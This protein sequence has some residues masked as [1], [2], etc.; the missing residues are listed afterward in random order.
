MMSLTPRQR[1]CLAFLEKRIRATG[2]G[3]SHREIC[4]KLNLKSPAS[5][6]RLLNGLE[7]RGAIAR[8]DRTPRAIAIL[9]DAPERCPH[10]GK[11]VRAG[12]QQPS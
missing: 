11:P 4:A 5:A 9:R 8:L 2:Q 7:R 3:P 6:W 1:Q 10:C 12:E